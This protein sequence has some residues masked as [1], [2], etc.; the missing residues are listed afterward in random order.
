MSASTKLIQAA[1]GAGGATGGDVLFVS[2]SAT[3]KFNAIDT[4]DPSDISLISTLPFSGQH[5]NNVLGFVLDLSRDVA[6]LLEEDDRSITSIDISDPSSM[7]DI[8][9]LSFTSLGFGDANGLVDAALDVENEVLYCVSNGSGEDDYLFSIDV[10]DT[11]NMTLLDSVVIYTDSGGD[12]DTD[13]IVI[14]VTNQIAYVASQ[15]KNTIRSYDISNPSSI[16]LDDTITLS[17]HRPIKM[18]LDLQ[19]DVLYAACRTA[20]QGL[21]S[22]DISN[23]SSMSELDFISTNMDGCR[24]ITIDFEE[25]VVYLTDSSGSSLEGAVISVDVSNPSAMVQ[26][27]RIA[28]FSG[29]RLQNITMDIFNKVVYVADFNDASI[30]A[31]DVSDPSS[32]NETDRLRL[33]TELNRATTPTIN[34]P[35]Y[36]STNAFSA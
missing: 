12:G 25:E 9:E 36:L 3:D 33:T 21:I 24:D 14:D 16:T 7:S 32:M 22:I 20:G 10:S 28:P 34:I 23:P 27:D 1:A 35:G 19:N 18:V 6:F 30:H 31:I 15:T 8:S 29:E 5:A 4:A 2:T 11:S 26:L 13:G 17:G